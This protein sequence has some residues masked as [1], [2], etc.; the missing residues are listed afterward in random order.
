MGNNK[1]EI[2]GNFRNKKLKN[3]NV[4]GCS[5]FG[6]IVNFASVNPNLTM[7]NGQKISISNASG[8]G[9][10]GDGDSSWSSSNPS[11][12]TVDAKGNVTAKRVGTAKITAKNKTTSSWY[13]VTVKSNT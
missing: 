8:V 6:G 13:M 11:V 12:A 7:I 4:S 10:I 5:S 3:I 9:I 2:N 1:S